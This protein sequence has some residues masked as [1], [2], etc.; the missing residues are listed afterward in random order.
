MSSET[1][2][3]RTID[4][5]M[6]ARCTFDPNRKKNKLHMTF[7]DT[8]V[9]VTVSD[10]DDKELGKICACIGGGIEIR[11]A[12]TEETWFISSRQLWEAYEDAKKD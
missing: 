10:K 5:K 3:D 6:K 8:T 11:D 4:L 7:A 12:E 1:E 2:A 9:T